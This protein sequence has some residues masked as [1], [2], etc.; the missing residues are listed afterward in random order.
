MKIIQTTHRMVLSIWVYVE[1][2]AKAPP[3]SQVVW[4]PVCGV[5]WS[6]LHG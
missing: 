2:D 6:R 3:N 5:L 1:E 4:A